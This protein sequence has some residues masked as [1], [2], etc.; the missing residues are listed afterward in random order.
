MSF[1]NCYFRF[2]SFNHLLSKLTVKYYLSVSS[3][4]YPSKIYFK[5][6]LNNESNQNQSLKYLNESLTYDLMK[7][8]SLSFSIFYSD[9]SYT[10][11]TESP[12]T[13]IT[14]LFSQIGGSLGL[15]VSFSIF[16]LLEII[17]LIILVIRGLLAK[18]SKISAAPEK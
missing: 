17:E 5:S 7:E 13:S 15:F 8:Y 3:Q 6:E 18:E 4:A 11:L 12:K 16:T 14:D 2:C 10:I 1:I 9:M